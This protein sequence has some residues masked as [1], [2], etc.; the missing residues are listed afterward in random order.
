LA[1][2]F[3]EPARVISGKHRSDKASDC[4][5]LLAFQRRSWQTRRVIIGLF[6]E[7]ESAGGIQRA[8]RHLA[9]V[10]TEFATGRGLEC[11]LLSLNDT[12][13]LHRMS[14]AAREFVFTGSERAKGRFAATAMRA[15]R[16]HA[17]LVI[18]A[19]PNLAPV[20]QAMRI[21]A[22][23]MKSI[24]VAHGIEVW[25]PL[26]TLRRRALGGSSLIL[27]PTQDTANHVA[28]QQQIPRDRIRVLPWALDPDFE[29]LAAST[30]Q[31]SLPANFPSGRV[32]LTV[33]RWLS[34][35]RYKG[36]D[37]LISALPRLLHEWN[38]LQL[39]AVGEGDDQPWLEQLAEGCGVRRH[40]HF[41]SG[42][43][44]SELA[45]C[46]S[47]CEIFALPSRGEG[48]GFV[49]LEAMARGKPVIG[50][51]H[52]GA[53]EVI[54]DGRTGYLVHHG[55]IPQLATSIETLLSDPELAREMGARGRERVN[56]DF[57]FSVFSKSLK[58]IFRELCE[59]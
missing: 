56:R 31:N 19:H 59:S 47:A 37:M 29:A 21:A 18:A 52:G 25:E 6:S 2:R 46:Y 24:V 14:V 40:V 8:G 42:L 58:K 43:K 17:K 44:Y 15:A 41:F 16:R 3:D 48:F 30:P 12:P 13:E 9:A 11:R 23:R 53:P 1:D 57:K 7:L 39:V 35:E 51:A 27:T 33:G 49:Y 34:S 22:P 45:A 32:L 4:N 10:M 50:G 54:D 38:D 55:D 36:M 28:S 26:S 20:A 5:G